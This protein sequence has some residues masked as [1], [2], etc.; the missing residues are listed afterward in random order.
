[1]STESRDRDIQELVDVLVNAEDE[2]CSLCGYPEGDHFFFSAREIEK[3]KKLNSDVQFGRC[4]D[5]DEVEDEF[6][7]WVKASEDDWNY[8]YDIFGESDEEAEDPCDED[9]M[10]DISS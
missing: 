8:V 4:E 1:M 9:F 3:L 5:P 2:I 6:C 10:R 7:Y